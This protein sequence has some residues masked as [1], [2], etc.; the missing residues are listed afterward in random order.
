MIHYLVIP[1]NPLLKIFALDL[2]F[3]ILEYT[4][5]IIITLD[6][7]ADYKFESVKDILHEFHSPQFVTS[8]DVLSH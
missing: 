7:S 6:S 4:A 5:K 3:P 2:F 1:Y 8:L